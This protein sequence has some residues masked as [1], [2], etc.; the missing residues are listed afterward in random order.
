MNVE[1]MRDRFLGNAA[2]L[3]DHLQA[4]QIDA[5]LNRAYQYDIPATLDGEISETTWSLS[6]VASTEDYAYPA[7]IVAP[8]EHAWI[9]DS[10]G[11]IPLM[12][13]TN[14]TLFEHRY[15]YPAGAAE[16]RPTAILFYGRS[17]K[18]APVPNAVYEIEIPSRGGSATALTDGGT[19]ENDTHAMAVVHAG[20]VEFLTEVG[21][22]ELAANNSAALERYFGRLV[23]VSKARPKARV[24]RRSF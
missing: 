9:N 12:V 23:T 24:P 20:L 4:G 14:P 22:D 7:Y 10:G 17:A 6:T 8:S 19:I 21:A 16:G 1:T 3:A 15:A 13:T 2:G 11:A 18:L 5:Y